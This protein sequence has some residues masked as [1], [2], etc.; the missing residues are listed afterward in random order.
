MQ[1]RMQQQNPEKQQ[2]LKAIIDEIFA[3]NAPKID[4]SRKSQISDFIISTVNGD[5]PTDSLVLNMNLGDSKKGAVAYILTNARLIIV[6]IEEKELQSKIIHLNTITSIERKLIDDNRIQF[7][8]F[9]QNGAAFGLRYSLSAQNITDFFQK[10]DRP[11]E[12]HSG[13]ING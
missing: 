5:N 13:G 7:T 11:R 3:L 10:V 1:D 4:E 6:D 9:L 12:S 2:K 8:I